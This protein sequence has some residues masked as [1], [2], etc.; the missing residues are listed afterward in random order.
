[1]GKGAVAVRN[2]GMNAGTE[3][4]TRWRAALAANGA[5]NVKMLLNHLDPLHPEAPVPSIGDRQP[6]PT[7]RFVEN[8]LREHEAAIER[9][10]TRR[11]YWI[12]TSAVIA[13]VAAW[14]AV[15]QGL[16]RG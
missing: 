13:A 2:W 4:E 9:K 11:F 5:S 14:I 16:V 1:M 7:R 12:V 6:W 3:N 15:W 10:E 8:W